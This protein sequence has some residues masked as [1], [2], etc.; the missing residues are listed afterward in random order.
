MNIVAVPVD[1]ILARDGGDGRILGHAGVGIV[2]A[3]GKLDRLAVGDFADV[4]VAAGDGVAFFFLREVDFIGAEF[5]ILQH[6]D[7]G[8]E[9]VIEVGLEA[10]EADGG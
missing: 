5:G 4:V 2:W 9:D 10:R 7:E 8:L 1:Q 3:V 6:V